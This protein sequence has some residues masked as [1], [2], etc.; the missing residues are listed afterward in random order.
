VNCQQKNLTKPATEADNQLDVM[1]TQMIK[2]AKTTLMRKLTYEVDYGSQK[3]QHRIFKGGVQNLA[4][5][6]KVENFS[7]YPLLGDTKSP[8]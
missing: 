5:A 8:I 1:M 2:L 7:V 6:S 3:G 4:S